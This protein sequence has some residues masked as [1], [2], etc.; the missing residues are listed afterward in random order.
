MT[1]KYQWELQ[2][3]INENRKQIYQLEKQTNI[4]ENSDEN[5][6]DNSDTMENSAVAVN[7]V[8]GKSQCALFN[9]NAVHRESGEIQWCCKKI[10]K[11]NTQWQ[12]YTMNILS[13]NKN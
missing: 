9:A 13:T 6:D 12:K 5:A 7:S 10:L 3:N 11:L 4:D 2:S 8:E 1:I